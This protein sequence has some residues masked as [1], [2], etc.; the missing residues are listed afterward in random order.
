MTKDEGE[1][2]RRVKYVQI[3]GKRIVGKVLNKERGDDCNNESQCQTRLNRA[4]H[5]SPLP[6]GT[7]TESVVNSWQS[8][9]RI[10]AQG[11]ERGRGER[12]INSDRT[13]CISR[14]FT[15]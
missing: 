6:S 5:L 4:R 2:G 10:L 15:R 12:A 3:G 14:I 9:G 13:D 11:T 8:G 7:R 1:G